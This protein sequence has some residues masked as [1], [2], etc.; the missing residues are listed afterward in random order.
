MT[1]HN[2]SAGAAQSV[3]QQAIEEAIGRKPERPPGFENLEAAP[4]RFQVID[5]DP[6]EVKR[7]IAQH[8]D[9]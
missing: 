6:A 4:Q 5:P 9:R 7:I 8:A 1:L 3:V 2:V